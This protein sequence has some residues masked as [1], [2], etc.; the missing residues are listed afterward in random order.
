MIRSWG[1]VTLTGAAQPWFGDVT[2]AA[3][4]LP[5]GD[6]LI[7]VTVASTTRYRVGDRFY[8]D[9]E[10]N[11]QDILLVDTITSSTV[12]SCKSEGDAKTHTHGSGAVIQLSIP[13]A[14]INVQP[15]STNTQTVFLGADNTVTNVPGGSVSREILPSSPPSANLSIGYNIMRTSDGW[16][17]GTAGDKVI[18]AAT[19]A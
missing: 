18:V 12:L 17:V 6:G 16:M 14:E 3:V 8:L 13:A 2:T 5:N 4:G 9:P 7:P 15:L 1:L 10:T 11:T 19:V